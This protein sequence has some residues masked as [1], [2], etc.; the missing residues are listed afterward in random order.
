MHWQR[1]SSSFQIIRVHSERPYNL[2]RPSVSHSA[3]DN[4]SALA[5]ARETSI[6]LS[7]FTVAQKNNEFLSPPI[8]SAPGNVVPVDPSSPSGPLMSQ[9]EHTCPGTMSLASTSS[10]SLPLTAS[11][12]SSALDISAMDNNVDAASR[13]IHQS[14]STK[15]VT[16]LIVVTPP[17]SK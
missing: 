9:N 11:R 6:S 16:S 7:S 3:S 13:K 15:S 2:S 5:S 4:H 10:I 12:P 17:S 8:V 14:P 1:L